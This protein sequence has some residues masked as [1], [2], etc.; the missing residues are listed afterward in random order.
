MKKTDEDNLFIF[1]FALG[2]ILCELLT[3]ALLFI[4]GGGK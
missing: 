1:G 2:V 3:I 4:A